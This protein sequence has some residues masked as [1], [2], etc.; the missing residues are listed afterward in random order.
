MWSRWAANIKDGALTVKQQKTGVTLA[1]PVHPELRAVLDATPSSTS[2]LSPRPGSHMA[3]MRS[4]SSFETGATRPD[5]RNA[6]RHMGC[7]RRLAEG[8]RKFLMIPPAREE[9][10]RAR[11][12]VREGRH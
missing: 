8:W 9:C 7:A 10:V 11:A 6:A 3:A 4:A 5:Y 12:R 1:I 2:T